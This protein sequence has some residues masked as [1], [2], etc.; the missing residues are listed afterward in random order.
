[1][2]RLCCGSALRASSGPRRGTYSIIAVLLILQAGTSLISA[3]AAPQVE[4][5]SV[6]ESTAGQTLFVVY[7][8]AIA[9]LLAFA[10]ATLTS[11]RI[12]TLFEATINHMNHGV[13]MFDEKSSSSA[14][15]D[16]AHVKAVLRDQFSGRICGASPKGR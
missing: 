2:Q 12:T 14:T 1:L 11:Q 15:T 5:T 13:A 16:L 4:P 7:A 3:A 8:M 6:L 9:F 10:L